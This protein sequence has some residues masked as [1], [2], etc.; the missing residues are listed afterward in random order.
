MTINHPNGHDGMSIVVWRESGGSGRRQEERVTLPRGLHDPWHTH[1]HTSTSTHTHKMF[2]LFLSSL[3]C[4][5]HCGIPHILLSSFMRNNKLILLAHLTKLFSGS[6]T[7][8]CYS[9]YATAFWDFTATS[10]AYEQEFSIGSFESTK[11]LKSGTSYKLSPP[12]AV[13][14]QLGQIYK[15]DGQTSS[16]THV[17]RGRYH[18]GCNVTYSREFI[19]RNRYMIQR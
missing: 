3:L 6:L 1:I 16:L 4:L 7:H 9:A 8:S 11:Q 10:I 19:I 5:T 18:H 14:F 17:Y 13:L 12:T 2:S 15:K